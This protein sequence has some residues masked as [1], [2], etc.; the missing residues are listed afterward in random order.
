MAGELLWSNRCHR[1]E[2]AAAGTALGTPTLFTHSQ[3]SFS[4]TGGMLVAGFTAALSRRF[5]KL[6]LLLQITSFTCKA[7]SFPAKS[8]GWGDREGF[9]SI[10]LL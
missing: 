8:L 3:M 1:Q 10:S 4:A 2:R 6:L 7:Y 9:A 5:L